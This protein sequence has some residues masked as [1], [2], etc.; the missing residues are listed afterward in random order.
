[1]AAFCF[2]RVRSPLFEIARVLVHFDHLPLHHKRESQ[3]D[4]TGCET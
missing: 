4:V 3:H 2:T 1:M